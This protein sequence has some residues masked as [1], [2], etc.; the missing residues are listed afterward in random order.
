MSSNIIQ[1]Q[2]ELSEQDKVIALFRFIQELNK[3]KQKVVLNIKDHPW[4]LALSDLHEDPENIKLHFCDRVEDDEV[5]ANGF[6]E[7]MLSVHKPEVISCPPPDLIFKNWLKDGWDNYKL[8]VYVDDSHENT[9]S[10]ESISNIE[11]FNDNEKRVKAYGSWLEKRD[12]WVQK[13][14]INDKTQNLFTELYSLYFELKRESETEEIIVANGIICD[15]ET[16][17]MKHPVLTH[18]VKIDF[19]PENNIVAIYDINTTTELYSVIFQYFQELGAN[20]DA[21]NQIRIDLAKNDY[22]PF[23]RNITPGFLKTLTHQLSA[24]GEY[25]DAKP[26]VFPKDSQIALYVDPCFIVRKRLDGTVK[27]I[28]QIIENVQKTG[29]IPSPIGNIVCGGKIE[30]PEDIGEKTVEEQL[31]S[32]GGESIDILLSKEANQEQLEIARR[33]EQYNAVIVQGPPGTGKTHTIANLIGH[34]LSQGKSVLVTSHTSKALKVLKEKVVPGL[35]DLCVSILDD[36]NLDMEQSIDGIT[37]YLSKNTSSSLRKSLELLATERREIINK[38]ADVRRKI[39]TV[40]RQEY[41]CI[42]LNGEGITPSD[43]AKFVVAHTEDLSYIPG[44]VKLRTELPLSFSDLSDLYR[45]N[46]DISAQDEVELENE[47][48]NPM[49]ILPPEDFEQTWSTLQTAKQKINDIALKKGWTVA[50]DP[51]EKTVSFIGEFGSFKVSYP[52]CDCIDAL[53]EYTSSLGKIENWMKHVAVDGKKGGNYRKRWQILVEAIIAVASYA[54]SIATDLF[55]KNISFSN[56]DVMASLKEPFEKIRSAFVEKGK[57]SLFLRSNKNIK[58]ALEAVKINGNIATSSADCDIVIHFIEL[59]NRRKQCA[60]YWDELL[61]KYDVPCFFTL[62][63]QNQEQIAEKWIPNI[64]RYLDWYATDYESLLNKLSAVGIPA[65]VIFRTDTMDSDITEAEKILSAI[66][67]DIVPICEILTSTLITYECALRINQLKQTLTSGKRGNSNICANILETI[68]SGDTVGYTNAYLE[69]KYT[70]SKYDILK[71]RID[72]LN[73]LEPYAPQWAEAIRVREGIHGK[74]IVPDNVEDA[75]KWKQLSGIIEEITQTSFE[76]LQNESVNLSKEYRNKTAEYA[77]KCGWYHLLK[78]TEADIDMEQA[79]QGWKL[80]IKK[81]G[82]ATGKRAPDLKARARILME[83]CQH[84][85]PCWIM[86]INRAL[87]SLNPKE[88][89]FDIVIIDEASQSDISSLAILYMGKK[90]IIVGDD[91][92]VSPVAVGVE[93]DKIKALE[94]VYIKGIIP[95]SHLYDAKTS[96]YDIAATTFKPLML[97]EHFRSVPEIIGFSNML[98]YNN[99]IKPL[100]DASSSNLLP[101]VVNY[102]VANGERSSHKTN[103]EE[104]EAIIALIQACIEQPE[105]AGKTFGIISLL[106]DEQVNVIQKLLEEKIGSRE[107]VERNI[108]CGNPANFQGDERDVVFLSIVDSGNGDGPISIRDFGA[109]DLYRKRYNVA[110]SRAKDQ[111]WVVD[112]LDPA[113][114]LKSGDIRKT[115]IEYSINP[116]AYEYIH[117]ESIEKSESPFEVAVADALKTRGYHVVHQ[118]EAGAYRIDIVAIYQKKKVA[119][120]CDGER[121]HSGEIQIREDMERQTILERLGWRFIRIRGSEYYSNTEKTI[122]RVVEELTEYGINPEKAEVTV[123]EKRSTDLLRRVKNR[124][125]NILLGDTPDIQISLFPVDSVSSIMSDS[126]MQQGLQNESYPKNKT[127]NEPVQSESSDCLLQHVSCSQPESSS[128]VISKAHP[129]QSKRIEMPVKLIDLES[130]TYQEQPESTKKTEKLA[131]SESLSQPNCS[132]NESSFIQS[133]LP[134]DK[135]SNNIIEFLKENN[136]KFIDKRPN[137]GALWIIGGRE[138][139]TIVEECKKLGV[140]FSYSEKGGRV[141]NHKPSWWSK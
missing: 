55:G 133:T 56:P 8:D 27:A 88:N 87:E 119:I 57:L 71:K 43:A 126:Q 54:E 136:V 123:S 13:R 115:L 117:K 33:I 138:L 129:V 32:V 107:I 84:A 47:I 124:A 20:L 49:L 58:S 16:Q 19:D 30:I 1:Q 75:W 121:Y 109:D 67:E 14:R 102:R 53:K 80:T 139:S 95:N 118:W 73:I 26:E 50:D 135:N 41:E 64:L 91:K 106:G 134:I 63:E 24:G 137:N 17:Q 114:D 69:L 60:V 22:H 132:Q 66:N 12:I 9:D 111:L 104:A 5:L 116:Q 10:S 125:G 25:Y 81:I 122:Q 46:E 36:S 34:F 99:E 131:Q 76:E 78:R 110:A 103:I 97:K 11:Y 68:D 86:P 83:K 61:S 92:Q 7:P 39:F 45:S 101:A 59:D 38:L 77:E 130:N 100:R 51:S 113:N 112:S 74:N 90:L 98:S 85:V 120:E 140:S 6:G 21:V 127:L 128:I 31:A 18:R 29:N 94:Q 79:L 65:D 2:N 3:L 4:S 108:L 15:T 62:D 23:D 82:K 35:Q 70:Y 96:I 40:I 52:S 48:P 141:T 44:K 89:Q 37:D 42:V 105:Y 28:E 93:I 72:M